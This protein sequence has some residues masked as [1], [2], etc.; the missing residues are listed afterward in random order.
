MSGT[1]H[2]RVRI[3]MGLC[4]LAALLLVALAGP[5]LAQSVG[6]LPIPGSPFGDEVQAPRPVVAGSGVDDLLGL[7]GPADGTWLGTYGTGPYSLDS[8]LGVVDVQHQVQGSWAGYLW[9]LVVW[10]ARVLTALLS[11]AFTVDLFRPLAGVI[12]GIVGALVDSIWRPLA[13]PIIVL[14][15]L[16]AAYQGIVRREVSTLAQGWVWMIAAVGAGLFFFTQPTRIATGVNTFA[17]KLSNT[18][19]D[20]IAAVDPGLCAQGQG[21]CVGGSAHL[22]EV[23]DRLW[24]LYVIKPYVVMEFGDGQREAAYL[25]RLL[26]A[27]TITRDDLAKVGKGGTT[28]ESLIQAKAEQYKALAADLQK[29]GDAFEWFSGRR[30]YERGMIAGMALVATVVGAIVL[31]VVAAGVLLAQLGLLL[32]FLLAPVFLALGIHPGI[33]RRVA[34]RFG[35]LSIGM[36]IQRIG[37]AILLA[38]LLVTSGSIMTAADSAGGWY[39][40]VILHVLLGAAALY[41]RKPF[42]NLLTTFTP[43]PSVPRPELRAGATKVKEA[44]G[45]GVA[46]SIGRTALIGRGVQAVQARLPA[47]GSG[48]KPLPPGGRPRPSPG[49]GGPKPPRGGDRGPLPP[50]VERALILSQDSAATPG[51]GG[52]PGPDNGSDTPGNAAAAARSARAT[53]GSGANGGRGRAWIPPTLAYQPNPE[54][55]RAPRRD[56][57][58]PYQ[59][60]EQ[61]RILEPERRQRRPTPAERM[62]AERMAERMQRARE[63]RREVR[64]QRRE[65]E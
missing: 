5:A 22:Q 61:Q 39:A 12:D 31:G 55:S 47:P 45:L 49:G 41:Y 51:N 18:A 36:L 53:A 37:L 34:T 24:Y 40:A 2:T 64:E 9:S 14:A 26:E 42:L 20:A 10:I 21:K 19:L 48:P 43:T 59:R 6:P 25:R 52:R 38:I 23:T 28:S 62:Q 30:N 58:V 32:A 46:Y 60:D 3:R 44:L 8:H 15:G 63:Q 7:K 13:I 33:G 17:A 65:T 56:L 16:W 54:A 1:S 27:K 57:H 4:A 35:H 50:D 11:W 29:D